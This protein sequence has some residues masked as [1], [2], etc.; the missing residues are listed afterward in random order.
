M[1][2]TPERRH[3]LESLVRP[4]V[5]YGLGDRRDPEPSEHRGTC[6]RTAGKDEK[7]TQELEITGHTGAVGDVVHGSKVRF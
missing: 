5:H 2:G 1:T 6:K 3:D 4:C 7:H